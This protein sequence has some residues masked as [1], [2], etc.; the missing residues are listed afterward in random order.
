MDISNMP[1][2]EFKVMIIKMLTGLEKEWRTSMRPL[3]KR[4]NREKNQS[5]IKNS[6]TDIKNTDDRINKVD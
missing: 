6:I 2:R 1:D 3:T 4:Q 5:E